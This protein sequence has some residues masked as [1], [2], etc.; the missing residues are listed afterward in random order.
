M[1]KIRQ[2]SLSPLADA[3]LVPIETLFEFHAL[4]GGKNPLPDLGF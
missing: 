2:Q 3:G 4:G 1:E